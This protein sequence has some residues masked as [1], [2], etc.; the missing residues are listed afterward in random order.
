MVTS[1]NLAIAIFKLH[2][3][4]NIAAACRH[5]AR[6]ATPRPGHPRAHASVSATSTIPLCR[7]T[8]VQRLAAGDAK[9]GEGIDH[10]DRPGHGAVLIFGEHA[11]RLRVDLVGHVL[12]VRQAGH[13]VGE[14]QRGALLRGV[15]IRLPPGAE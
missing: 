3:T 9:P 4:P 1:R 13:R 15:Q 8:G 2:G 6:A 7:R 11:G 5:H 10:G 14:R 12:G